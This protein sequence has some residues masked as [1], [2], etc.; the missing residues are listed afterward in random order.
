MRQVTDRPEP[1]II[2][3]PS[4]LEVATMSR[5][6]SQFQLR[7]LSLNTLRA[8]GGQQ[9]LIDTTPQTDGEWWRWWWWGGARHGAAVRLE[10]VGDGREELV[11]RPVRH[12]VLVHRVLPVLPDQQH[13]VHRKRV[14]AAAQ[15][16]GDGVVDGQAPLLRP[17]GAEVALGDVR[18]VLVVRV[19]LG[20][21]LPVRVDAE[22]S[23]ASHRTAG[24]EG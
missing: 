5:A 4:D 16:L 7:C 9:G 21:V 23:R 14:A 2:G 12:A 3:K 15:R 11:P 17:C 20:V 18:V 24:W 1:A 8:Q 13:R 6:C 19:D 22:V 10:H